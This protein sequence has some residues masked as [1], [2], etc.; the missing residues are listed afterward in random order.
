MRS[1]SLRFSGLPC[2]YAKVDL[3]PLYLRCLKIHPFTSVLLARIIFSSTYPPLYR[4][5]CLISVSLSASFLTSFV[6]LPLSLSLSRSIL[7]LL[8]LPHLPRSPSPSVSACSNM[9]TRCPITRL[10]LATV[11]PPPF[12]CR[13]PRRRKNPHQPR[14]PVLFFAFSFT[15]RSIHPYSSA[16]IAP[17]SSVSYRAGYLIS[18]IN[19]GNHAAPSWNNGTEK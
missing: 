5:R 18:D 4:I 10:V 19:R 12:I 15:I 7:F 13:R 1:L 17:C 2:A 14:H 6:F 8:A 9:A 3:H 11:F 16:S